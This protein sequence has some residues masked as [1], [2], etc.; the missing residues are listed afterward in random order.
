MSS[1]ITLSWPETNVAL[2]TLDMPDKSAN[3]LSSSVLQELDDHLDAL[4]AQD[5]A[6][7]VIIASAKPGIFVA[8]ADLRE[9]A[10]TLDVDAKETAAMCDRGQSLFR[11]LSKLPFVTIAAI[12]GI[13]VGGGAELSL[14]CDRRVLTTNARTGFGFPEV[15][16]GL[17]PGWGGTVR[18][19]RIVGLSNAVEMITSGENVD[20]SEAHVMGLASDLVASEQLLDA[21]LAMVEREAES[22]AYRRDREDWADP[23][24]MSPDELGFLAASASAM[25]LGQSKGQYPAPMA[26]LEVLLEG[27]AESIDDA[28]KREAEGFAALFGSPVNR[29]LL[30]LF[31]LT[32]HNKKDRGVD[33]ADARANHVK[34]IGVVGAGIMGAGIAAATLKRGLRTVLSDVSEEA[35]AKGAEQVMQ[36]AS[37]DRKENG[38]RAEKAM[39]VGGLL[40]LGEPASTTH[41]DI[42]IE[43]I[44][45]NLDIKQKVLA[46][47]ESGMRDDA[48]LGSNTSTIPI[49]KLAAGL[50]RPERFCG[51]HF[52][53]PVRRMKL[54]EVIRG[55]A[56]SD[57][58]VATAV[59][60]AK[61]IGKMPIVVN[62]GP[63]FLVNRLLFPYMNESLQLLTEGVPI[64]DIE[65]SATRFGMPLGPLALY[66]MVGL[67]TS[68]YAGR[69]MWE[70]FPDRIQAL[71]VLPALVKQGR[72]GQK[73]GRGFFSYENRKRKAQPDPEALEFLSAYIRESKSLDREAITYRLFVPMVLEATRVLSEG[74]VRDVRDVDLGMIFGLGFPAFRGGL[75]HWADTMGAAEI[76]E[77]LKPLEELG[78]RFQPTEL[79]LEMAAENRKFYG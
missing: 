9:F 26:A 62:D 43:A 11:R 24:T 28:M 75:L 64:E 20:G 19:P 17:F 55:E 21:A 10:A 8:G 37:Y 79:L 13:C 77:R 3:V 66:D 59:A 41:A 69:V 31:F 44:V 58:T 12:D 16:L 38:V 49:T 22:E 1:T 63:G 27:S 47:L 34:S 6:K 14:W 73:S 57:D 56:T 7:G 30:N 23:L 52:F 76:V 78:T 61:R 2:L 4:S 18:L 33:S 54:V 29:S 36:D 72:L 74:L 25:I 45:E 46:E 51:I 70:A 50:Q 42:V 40:N 35:L 68:L 65:K 71:P 60:Y 5:G 15:K 32:D 53:N 67:D 39:Q 48:V